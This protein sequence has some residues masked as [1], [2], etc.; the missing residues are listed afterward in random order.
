MACYK[1]GILFFDP[2]QFFEGGIQMI[3]EILCDSDHHERSPGIK[4]GYQYLGIKG[5][6]LKTNFTVLP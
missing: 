3:I 1:L 6:T 2:K 5:L 4:F